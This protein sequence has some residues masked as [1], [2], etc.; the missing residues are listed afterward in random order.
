MI[1]CPSSSHAGTHLRQEQLRASANAPRI[2]SS[3]ARTPEQRRAWRQRRSRA[4]ECHAQTLLDRR[5]AEHVARAQAARSGTASTAA[6]PSRVACSSARWSATF[7]GSNLARARAPTRPIAIQASHQAAL[8]AGLPRTRGRASSASAR[9][10]FALASGFDVEAELR[11]ADD[12]S[13]QRGAGRR[14]PTSARAVRLGQQRLR[15]RRPTRTRNRASA[16]STSSATSCSEPERRSERPVEQVDSRAQVAAEIGA[17]VRL[18]R[19]APPRVRPAR[20]VRGRARRG[21]CTACS[22]W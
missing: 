20:I 1:R 18:P 19:A 17:R 3:I 7:R 9:E 16:R 14:R 5:R 21:S 10:L 12:P 6:S 22:R 8:V 2:A 15:V 11:C 4:L 13:E